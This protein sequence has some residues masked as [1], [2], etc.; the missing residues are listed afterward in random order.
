VMDQGRIVESGKHHE[1]LARQ[2][3][4][5]SLHKIQFS[6]SGPDKE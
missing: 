6:E 3:H 4:Y 5:A 1:L 2:G